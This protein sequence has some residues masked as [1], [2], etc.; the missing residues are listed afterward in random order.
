MIFFFFHLD[1][2]LNED[3]IFSP[4]DI[5]NFK[6]EFDK[7]QKESSP[8][9]EEE[10]EE[11]ASS[12]SNADNSK[13]IDNKSLTTNDPVIENGGEKTAIKS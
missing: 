5:E 9:I 2:F 4:Q 10:T 11:E 7:R 1:N 8:L 6:A 13:S 12:N 3:F